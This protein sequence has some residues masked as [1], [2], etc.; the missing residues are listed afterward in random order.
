MVVTTSTLVTPPPS[1]AT[2]PPVPRSVSSAA[3]RTG[4]LRGVKGI[5]AAKAKEGN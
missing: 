5:M 3:R 1:A 2:G 4:R